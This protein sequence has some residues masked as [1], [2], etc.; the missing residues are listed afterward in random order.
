[1][2]AA[3]QIP[4]SQNPDLT[5][6]TIKIGGV[7][8]S[9]EVSVLELEICSEINK[10][11]SFVF[12]IQDG[13]AA[14]E[15]FTESDKDVFLPGK[16]IEI[17]L[18][19]HSDEKVVFKGIVTTISNHIREKKTWLKISSKA[20]CVKATIARK[21]KVFRDQTLSEIL[22]DILDENKLKFE[23]EATTTKLEQLTQY[24]IS[25]WDF[26]LTQCNIN[27]LIV[28]VVED[29]V[30]I[31]SPTLTA[32]NKL[33]L[34]FP[35]TILDYD[36]EIDNRIQWKSIKARCWDSKNQELIEIEANEPSWTEPGNYSVTDLSKGISTAEFE[37]IVATTIFEE[38]QLQKYAD[39]KLLYHRAAKIKG[40]V[41][42]Q[43]YQEVF[44]GDMIGLNGV[45]ARFTGPV[46]VK[47]VTHHVEKEKY[48]TKVCFGM[49]P[50][51]FAKKINPYDAMSSQGI[52][53]SIEGLQIGIVTD[54][55]DPLNEFRV[56]V[57]LPIIE[58]NSGEAGT[59]A[60]IASMDA[61][62]LRGHYYMPEIGDEVVCACVGGDVQNLV[63]LGMLYSS[64]NPANETPSNKN[65]I[66]S[67]TSREKMKFTFDDE[68]KIVILE[69]PGK[70]IITIDDKEKKIE[71]SDKN[72]NKIVMD[73]E[74]ITIESY[75]NLN[76][77][78]K[79]KISAEAPSI[80]IDGSGSTEIKGGVI[81]LN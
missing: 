32:T 17:K 51:W 38:N 75:K 65:H 24:W 12:T 46:Y 64:A 71:I 48:I 4:T 23:V 62:N 6:Y 63:V 80:S 13:D 69:T 25:D 39:A 47:C 43:G 26:I 57:N 34:L 3:R 18:G 58:N 52:L 20:S 10:I 30:I 72:K 54:L 31:K 11:P 37:T 8:L 21:N 66:K 45:G 16:E 74:G 14:S 7:E 15:T 50:N 68:N 42:F 53:R 70:G 73:A 36:A 27:G 1:M 49:E 28:T 40:H 22:E 44:P 35:A 56:K 59:W 77:K 61:G 41:S 19:Y 76:L 29:K 2:T 79:A 81:K 9:R 33:D 78:A 60:R 5:T 67:Y 55:E